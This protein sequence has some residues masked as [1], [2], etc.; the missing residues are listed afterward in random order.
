MICRSCGYEVKDDPIN[1]QCLKCCADSRFLDTDVHQLLL[2]KKEELLAR[3]K[4]K[5][6]T[7]DGSIPCGIT[8]EEILTEL[9]R[10][11]FGE[12]ISV[13]IY[14]DISIFLTATVLTEDE[15]EFFLREF[16]ASSNIPHALIH[17]MFSST[18]EVLLDN[19]YSLCVY[20]S[21]ILREVNL[22]GNS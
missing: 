9:A 2:E 19:I 12:R 11:L 8:L 20:L 10:T 6:S 13:Y 22:H 3:L 1:G 21:R 14:P 5:I 17:I 4:Q 16:Y 7:E 15:R 18:F